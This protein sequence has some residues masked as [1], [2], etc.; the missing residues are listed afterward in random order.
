MELYNLACKVFG[1]GAVDE[2]QRKVKETIANWGYTKTRVLRVA[3]C[4]A[5]LANRSPRLE[6]LTVESL[7]TARKDMASYSAGQSMLR[8]SRVLAAFG[9]IDKPLDRAFTGAMVRER[10]T[11]A[12]AEA[13][14]EVASEW[15][16]CCRRW[17]ETATYAPATRQFMYYQ[18][19]HMGLW[20]A[21][22]HPEAR[23]P[24]QWTRDIALAYVAHVDRMVIGEW[25][26][27]TKVARDR[28]GRPLAPRSKISYLGAAR[29]FFR[30]CQEWGWIPRR[31]DPA[32]SFAAPRSIT[33]RIG[34]N[35]R[36][37][38]DDF[39]LKLLGAG[40]QLTSDDLSFTG[41]CRG[42]QAQI[43]PWYPIEMVR[44]LVMV[45]FFA[46]LR[47]DEIRRLR[48]GCIRWR[49]G[50][51]PLQETDA[52]GTKRTCWLDVP[53]N[54]TQSAFTKPVDLILGE[55]A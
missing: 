23:A 12:E 30:D 19:L 11:A 41:N 48:V 15:I 45:W 5:L 1:Q 44:A 26:R 49:K 38:Q 20:A 36:V 50:H 24:E 54:K 47:R 3:V 29:M 32:R 2:A 53:V 55:V 51:D 37:I 39:W 34:P 7:V 31:F 35:P 27:T 8:L 18:I 10:A 52:S 22:E 13:V 25:R 28:L 42:V 46:G 14:G 33:R 17:R 43:R 21:R 4:I 9:I 6:D 40:L 16:E